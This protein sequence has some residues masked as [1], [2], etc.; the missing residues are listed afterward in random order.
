MQ[1]LSEHGAVRGLAIASGRVPIL[2]YHS[3]SSYARYKKSTIS[4]QFFDEQMGYLASHNYTPISVTQFAHSITAAN[5]ELP[6][7]P[8]VL[9][10]DDGL[11]DFYTIALPALRRYGFTASLYVV[12]AFV[13]GTSRWLEREGQVAQPMLDWD[14]LAEI[15]ESGIE[16]GAHSHNHLPLDMLSEA[17]A[18]EEIVRSRRILEERLD[19][20]ISS[21][22]YPYGYY[23]SKV[24]RLVREAGY[25]SACAV[26]YASS[27]LADDPFALAR[28]PVASDT[29]VEDFAALVT[30]AKP[31]VA[32]TFWRIR[33][34][35]W[36]SLRRFVA[37]SAH[38][39]QKQTSTS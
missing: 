39:L 27:S 15:S 17:A 37:P 5:S 4:P 20:Q 6:E 25:S 35:V 14:Q 1:R 11:A 22:A 29:K 18:R 23:T 31:P 21:F 33:S 13:R 28:L 36:R 34:Y 24:R 26:R 2:M 16:C 30:G 10:F 9:T 3:L 32:L 38:I 19:R 7:R 12:T 8:V